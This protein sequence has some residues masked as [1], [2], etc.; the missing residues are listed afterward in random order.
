M[1]F[2]LL[3]LG[4]LLSI[5]VAQADEH[6][7]LNSHWTLTSAQQLPPQAP[8]AEFQCPKILNL[9]DSESALDFTLGGD[10]PADSPAPFVPFQIIPSQTQMIGDP[11]AWIQT[12]RNLNGDVWSLTRRTCHSDTDAPCKEPDV[13]WTVTAR[14]GQLV[15]RMDCKRERCEQ[16]PI[17]MGQCTYGQ[18]SGEIRKG[19]GPR[20]SD[21][22]EHHHGRGG[23]Y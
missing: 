17:T 8:G 20:Q 22:D 12:T 2:G 21:E 5:A 18:L 14:T 6:A 19:S 9:S 11:H 4:I 3:V 10:A 7:T 16:A 15:V 13:R 23:G 1:R